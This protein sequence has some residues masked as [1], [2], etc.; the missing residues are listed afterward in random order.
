MDRVVATFFTELDRSTQDCMVFCIG[1]TNRP[2]MLDPALLRPG[3][4]DRMVYLGLSDLDRAQILKV[5]LSKLK[6]EPGVSAEDLAG[7]AADRLNAN[8]TGADLASVASGALMLAT[9]RLCDQAEEEL[10]EAQTK[11]K[12]GN[13]SID[14]ILSHWKPEDLEP[15]VMLEDLLT[16]AS[17]VSPS[18]DE[19]QL[20]QY[21]QLREKL[22]SD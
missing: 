3:R 21:E 6:L 13:F 4:L 17:K 16:A 5:H 18:V 9:Q 10:I 14:H 19:E 22:E 7:K 2:D 1:A 15:T 20:A 11:P 8:L 12:G